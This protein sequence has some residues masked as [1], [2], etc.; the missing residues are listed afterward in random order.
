MGIPSLCVKML[1]LHRYCLQHVVKVT[2]LQ[3][4]FQLMYF[5][6]HRNSFVFPNVLEL[7][8]NNRISDDTCQAEGS[9][10]EGSESCCLNSKRDVRK[11]PRSHHGRQ[12]GSEP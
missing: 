7:S 9:H 8:V 6:Y 12:G 11:I 5:K 1:H 3:G 10:P 2:I 4:N